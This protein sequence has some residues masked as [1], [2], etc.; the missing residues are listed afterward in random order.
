[1]MRQVQKR[2]RSLRS[3]R[4]MTI[5]E[6]M[7]AALILAASSLAVLNLIASGARSNYRSEQSQV[8]ADRLQ[9]EAEQIKQLADSANYDRIALT[10]TPTHSTDPNSPD[11]RVSG[12]SFNV[13]PHGSQLQPMVVDT[14]GMAPTSTF[15]TGDVH[16]TIHRFV[17]WQPDSAC[18]NCL[19]RV[20]VAI[21]LDATASGGVRHY[22]ELQ[23]VIADPR[24]PG[25]TSN[26]PPPPS[27]ATPWSYWLTD[28]PCNQPSVS[29]P[30]R[31]PLT[32]NHKAHNTRATCD[33][34]MKTADNCATVIATTTCT[35]GA[36]D[37]MVTHPPQ[38]SSPEPLYNFATDVIDQ[39]VNA[40]QGLRLVKPATSGCPALDSPVVSDATNPYRFREIHKWVTAP[41][42]SGFNVQLDGNGT[43]N[44]WTR[45]VGN[46]SSAGSICVWLFQRQLNV[47]GVPIDTPATNL[48]GASPPSDSCVQPGAVNLTYF[49]CSLSAWPSGPKWHEVSIPLHFDLN[50]LLPNSQLGLAIQVERSGT[51]GGGLQF[52]YDEPSYE[53]RLE[54]NS[55][56]LLPCDVSPWPSC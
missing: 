29:E 55:S 5:A 39:N 3:E 22:Q 21:Q 48:Y 13:A 16:G 15:A 20:T 43:V 2:L 51:S 49:K 9:S 28:T 17:T 36:A 54:V 31:Q 24:A 25:R 41:I 26:P 44:L 34:G 45:T 19:K 33:K 53:S 11:F 6:V 56:S 23:S 38:N 35:G 10:A 42:P 4:G 52:Y 14:S 7:I 37:L 12:T 30:D 8:V 50:A 47:L 27:D 40:D 18:S 1:M 46:Q 32:G